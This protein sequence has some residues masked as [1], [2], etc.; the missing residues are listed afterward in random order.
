MEKS[1]EE[2]KEIHN[3]QLTKLEDQINCQ[4]ET[5]KRWQFENELLSEQYKSITNELINI[6]RVI[7]QY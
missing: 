1:T 6:E 7:N 4:K 2:M 3:I 5:I